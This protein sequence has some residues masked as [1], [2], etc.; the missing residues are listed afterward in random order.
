[1]PVMTEREE[2]LLSAK[3]SS[4]DFNKNLFENSK[5]GGELKSELQPAL[6]GC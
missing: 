5:T 2:R 4:D 6:H 1:M 3:T